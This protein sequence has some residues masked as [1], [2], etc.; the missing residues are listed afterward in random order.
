MPPDPPAKGTRRPI[1]LG[2]YE[3][4]RHIATGGMGAVYLARDTVLGREVALK[5]LP[6]EMAK[7]EAA[8]KRFEQEASHAAKLRHENIV[9]LFDVGEVNGAHFLAMEF[10]EGTDL[11]EYISRKGRLDAEEAR[12]IVIQAAK[13]LDHAYKQGIIHRDIK[14]SNF[15]IVGQNDQLVVKMTDLG[16]ARKADDDET[17]LTRDGTT[18]GTVDYMAPEQAR[19]SRKADIRSDIY[20]LGCTLY[21]MLAGQAPF[22]EGGLT[23]KL[24]KHVEEEP[25]DVRQFNPKVSDAL[26]TVLGRML[27]KKPGDRYQTPADLLK[28]L[29]H[30]ERVAVPG[31]ERDVLAGLALAMDEQPA[32]EKK[33]PDPA[34]RRRPP[35]SPGPRGPVHRRPMA[36]KQETVSRAASETEEIAAPSKSLPWLYAAGGG[37]LI[38]LV[39]V[40]VLA[41]RSGHKAA[42]LVEGTKEVAA[43]GRET[44]ASPGPATKVELKPAVDLKPTGPAWLYPGAATLPAAELW[45]K[46]Q[47]PWA[48]DPPPPPD[49]PVFKVSRLPRNGE[50]RSFASLAA[51]CAGAEA[52]RLT[53]IE[54]DDNGPLFEAPVAVNGRSLILRAAPQR[55]PLLVWDLGAATPGAAGKSLHFLSLTQGSLTLEN[56]DVVLKWTESSITEPVGLVQVLDGDFLARRCTFSVAGTHPAGLALARLDGTRPGCK[57]RLSHCYGRG[58]GLVALDL[59]SPAAEALVDGSLLVGGER[60]LLHVACRNAQLT[61]VRV[62]RSTLVT[63][64][65][66]VQVRPASPADTNPA[67]NWF[68]WDALLTRSNPQTGGELLDVRE[69]LQT[70]A[71]RWHADNCLYAGWRTLLAGPGAIPWTETDL[72][73]WHQRWQQPAGDKAVF[74]TWPPVSPHNLAEIPADNY[75]VKEADKEVSFAASA[76]PRTPLGCDLNSLPHGRDSWLAWTYDRFVMGTVTEAQASEVPAAVEGLYQGERIDLAKT[77]LGAHLQDV[78]KS[79]PF[80]PRVVMQLYSSGDPQKTRPSSPI[81]VQGCTLVLAF[82]RPEEKAKAPALPVMLMPNDKSISRQDGMIDVDNGSLEIIG[83]EIRFPNY[84]LALLPPYILRVRG[85][86][87]RL[88][89]CRLIG[90]LGQA[91]PT[92]RGLIRLDGPDKPRPEGEELTRACAVT[93]SVLISGR[94][95]LLSAGAGVR[96]RVQQSVVLAGTDAISFDPGPATRARVNV[97]C[98]LEY[99]TLAAKGAILRVAD[100]PHLPGVLEPLVIQSKA[101]VFLNPF[102]EPSPRCG[103]LRY[104]GDALARGLL[105]WQAEGNVY[106]AKRLAYY[107][108]STPPAAARQPHAMLARLWGSVGDRKAVLDRV[109]LVQR[110]F[111]LDKLD[112]AKGLDPLA[113]A[114][115]LPPVPRSQERPPGADLGQLGIQKVKPPR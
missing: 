79:L 31:A 19:D 6:P 38:G 86:D 14:P 78:Q 72:N 114:L 43:G 13:A 46:L 28:D 24:Y 55:R 108:A 12:R 62:A 59:R 80:A 53:I 50:E 7:N 89:G 58:A 112:L 52:G 63:E 49:T 98:S 17:R 102:A 104:E 82:E 66:L 5:V 10:I 97:Q 36:P 101:N 39:V 44:A 47:A 2:K 111:D 61:T 84:N 69:C 75:R 35:P 90:P 25:P 76:D 16:L 60:P 34:P 96:L 21:H 95:G 74:H 93:E 92:Y 33:A 15:L 103:L 1:R 94:A 77:D 9:T 73:A 41:L 22:P 26:R 27:A 30:L 70:N 4:I 64:Q 113:L 18:V 42:P 91:P 37:L 54:I 3:V 71:L 51:A 56:I 23:E 67:L 87:L 106:D 100:V 32:A 107:V 11:H 57:A 48:K 109:P 8:R 105:L 45:E 29:T 99:N 20:S 88:L 40:G 85:G 65:T 81:H 110:T 83:G 68:G 115:T